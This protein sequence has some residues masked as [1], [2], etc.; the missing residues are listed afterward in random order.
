MASLKFRPRCGQ[1]RERKQTA[2]HIVANSYPLYLAVRMRRYG[3]LIKINPS[4]CNDTLFFSVQVSVMSSSATATTSTENTTYQLPSS[5]CPIVVGAKND[6]LAP[7]IAS[8][9]SLFDL[10]GPSAK[11]ASRSSYLIDMKVCRLN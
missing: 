4:G 10:T 9:S 7:E 1:K 5:T 11:C 8:S 3:S 2:V 6:V